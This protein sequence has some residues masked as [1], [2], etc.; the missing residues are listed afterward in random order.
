MSDDTLETITGKINVIWQKSDDHQ[1]TLGVLMAEAKTKVEAGDPFAEGLAWKVYVAIHF[2]KKNGESRSLRS[3]QQLLQIGHSPDPA[4]K[5]QEIRE[6][7]VAAVQVQRER[8]KAHNVVHD[9]PPAEVV[10]PIRR[11]EDGQVLDPVPVVLKRVLI[12]LRKADEIELVI[13]KKLLDAE[14][15][16]RH[17]GVP[18]GAELMVELRQIVS[19]ARGH[20]AGSIGD[21]ENIIGLSPEPKRDVEF[22]KPE[23]APPKLEPTPRP[24]P[25][26]APKCIKPSG[27]CGYGSCKAKGQCQF[28]PLAA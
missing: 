15:T 14:A 9:D 21:I 26:E 6:A 23:V 5:S 18:A 22:P 8:E 28:K 11:G 1:A 3:V 16:L 24:V 12:R 7:K 13:D 17:L 20:R 25:G 4:Q 27:V 10:E 19:R 2:K